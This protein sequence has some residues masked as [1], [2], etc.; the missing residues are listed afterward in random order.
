MKAPVLIFFSAVPLSVTLESF[1]Q[2]LKACF[3]MED[4]ACMEK[5][6]DLS[7]M[8]NLEIHILIGTKDA[9]AILDTS[10]SG[11]FGLC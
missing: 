10:Q 2:P 6:S 3:P 5:I 4:T 1:L 11:D 9:D 7:D 8:G